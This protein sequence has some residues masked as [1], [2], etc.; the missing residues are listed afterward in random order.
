MTAGDFVLAVILEATRQA[1]TSGRLTPWHLG[2]MV[3][4][5]QEQERFWF[6]FPWPNE[7]PVVA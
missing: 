4:V 3:I 2:G 1:Y 5:F 7:S 6:E